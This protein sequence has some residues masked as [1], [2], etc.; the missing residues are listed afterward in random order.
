MVGEAAMLRSRA[1]LVLVAVGLPLVTLPSCKDD[2]IK[3][4]GQGAPPPPAPSAS[5]KS[6]ACAGGGGQ[7]QDSQSSAFFARSVGSYCVDPQG[8]EKVYGDKEKFSMDQVCTTAFD[9]ECEVYKRFGLKRVVSLRYVDGSKPNSVELYLNQ[10][11]DP[12]GAFAMYTKR[13]AADSDPASSKMK[14]LVAGGAGAL[15][16]SNAYVWKGPYLLEITFNSDDPA[17]TRDQ[18][19]A[20]SADACGAIGKAIADKLPGTAAKLPAVAALPAP[21]MVPLGVVFHPKDALGIAGAGAA[22][23]GFYKD[24]TKRW[25]A[26]AMPRDDADQAKDAMKAIKSR[27]G[28]MPLKDVA[29]DEAVQ[30]VVQ[31]SKDGPKAEYVFA[32]KG[33]LVAGVGD[34]ELV[35]NA[36]EPLD[37]QAGVR[38]T[39]DEKLGMLKALMSASAAP[40]PA[41][42]GSAK[43]P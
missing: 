4:E 40:A 33:T 7:V 28:A 25:R 11:N 13:V 43:K 36:S 1:L 15:G 22:A 18:I 14:P 2:D 37:K 20:A 30:V 3:K 29:G 9:G 24:G 23:I 32:R 12:A 8:N 41:P 21:N 42:S 10:F 16:G 34:E 38:L 27:P 19:A 31:E 35:L 6:N 17:M 26:I 39:R 5:T